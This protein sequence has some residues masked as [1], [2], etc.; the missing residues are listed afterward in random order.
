MKTETLRTI[1]KELAGKTIFSCDF[2]KKDGTPRT[3]VC[4]LGVK[5]G[6]NGKGS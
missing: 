3:M 1:I 6:Q 4:R 5:K 2:T